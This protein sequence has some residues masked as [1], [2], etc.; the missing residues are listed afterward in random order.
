M[1]KKKD[2]RM[3]DIAFFFL[4]AVISVSLSVYAQEVN[5]LTRDNVAQVV[6]A[7][8]T[9]TITTPV[10]ATLITPNP[11]FADYVLLKNCLLKTKT[12]GGVCSLTDFNNDGL[13][14]FADLALAKGLTVSTSSGRYDLNGDGTAN[15]ADLTSGATTPVSDM[16]LFKSCFFKSQNL[17]GVCALSDFNGDKV[18][19]FAD[20]ALLKANNLS[21]DLSVVNK[22]DLNSDG[23]V[24]Y[25]DDV[26][27]VEPANLGLT[28]FNLL[29]YCFFGKTLGVCS[30]ADLNND[31]AINFGDLALAK[32]KTGVTDTASVERYDLNG[33]GK[34]SY[35]DSAL[36]ATSTVTDLNLFKS[37]FFK[38][39]PLTGV[40][41]ISDFNDDGLI[42]FA[43]LAALKQASVSNDPLQNQKY[44]L[45]GD[46][47]VVSSAPVDITSPRVTIALSD[48]PILGLEDGRIMRFKVTAP[49]TG[50]VE[51]P[52]FN[53]KITPRGSV[54]LKNAYLFGYSDSSFSQPISGV[55]FGG[56]INYSTLVPDKTVS[57]VSYY[58]VSP[59]TGSGGNT[60]VIIPAG[61]T[62]FF[63]LR[64]SSP[65]ITP[66]DSVTSELYGFGQAVILNPTSVSFTRKTF[67][68]TSDAGGSSTP[69]NDTYPAVSVSVS[70]NTTIV[71]Q[72]VTLS[73]TASD[74]KGV[75]GVQF[76]VNGVDQGSEDTT[77]PYTFSY[78][79]ASPGIYT[80]T[81]VARDTL[82]QKTTS[83]SISLTVNSAPAPT[84]PGGK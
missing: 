31:G 13:T 4:V 54:S 50:D 52:A 19:N 14:N 22:Y 76:K 17:N 10:T 21:T 66:G 15:Y 9:G 12:A 11:V 73:A 18:I 29:R 7:V 44:D 35:V 81:A 3:N 60:V 68:T 26:D 33:D 65:Q 2:S 30:L 27:L 32:T 41:A 74:D 38:Q 72:S 24:N 25:A 82:G 1:K 49:S 69:V 28:D 80:V 62:R 47:R 71:G 70:P 53:F 79:Q 23:K 43:D 34:V 75:A 78:T 83:N 36:L 46:G 77:S 45:N 39:A 55:S 59:K 56:Q 48:L 64:I 5:T 40:C 20:L 63:E 61:T 57:G 6:G 42:N 84:T 67:N 58:T 51:L 16:S 8:A 37:C